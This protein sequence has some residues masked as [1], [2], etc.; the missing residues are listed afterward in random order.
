MKDLNHWKPLALATA[1]AQNGQLLPFGP[2]HFVGQHWG[3]VTASP[4]RRPNTGAPVDPVRM[5]DPSV[6]RPATLSSRPRPSRSLKAFSPQLD[7]R[8][9]V[10]IDIS[11]DPGRQSAGHQRWHRVRADRSP[12]ALDAR[13]GAP[14]RLRPRGGRV[15]GRRTQSETPPGHWNTLANAV[16]DSAGF[17]R[18][19]GGSGEELDP[20]SGT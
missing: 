14:G 3:H 18:R 4:Y 13:A 2:Q 5:P 17:E 11:P 9:G 1:I 16:T 19:I 15:L 20:S 7:P 6:T 12:R 8:D 10:V